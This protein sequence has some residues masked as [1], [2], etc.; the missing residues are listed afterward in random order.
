MH[1]LLS[2]MDLLSLVISKVGDDSLAVAKIAMALLQVTGSDV[3]GQGLLF[4]GQHLEGLKSVAG[5]NDT[6]RYRVF[7]VRE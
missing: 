5:K 1:I 7:E 6:I 3:K 2:D 4:G